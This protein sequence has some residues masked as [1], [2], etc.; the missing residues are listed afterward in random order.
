MLK[1][2]VIDNNESVVLKFEHSLRSLSKWE[3]K[4]KTSFLKT[5]SKTAHEMVDYFQCMLLEDQDPILVLRLSPDQLD[6]LANYVNESFT[7]SSVPKDTDAKGPVET[8]TSELI[9]YWMDEL[10]IDWQAQDWHLSRLMVLIEIT[11]YKRQ[12]P[13][14]RRTM[15]RLAEWREIDARNKARFGTKG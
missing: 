9:Y 7:A 2:S 14:K 10:N 4:T 3:S 15:D 12:P 13:K 6:Q 5:P 1:L 11:Q 8:V